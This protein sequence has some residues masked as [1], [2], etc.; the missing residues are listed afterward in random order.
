MNIDFEYQKKTLENNFNRILKIKT[1]CGEEVELFF[2]ISKDKKI[3]DICFSHAGSR[4]TG[5][6]LNRICLIVN[7]KNIDYVLLELESEFWKDFELNIAGSR[8]EMIEELVFS[9]K[10]LI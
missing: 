3:K 7:N 6:A 8:K 4:L 5:V 2:N 10:K 9:I 1:Q